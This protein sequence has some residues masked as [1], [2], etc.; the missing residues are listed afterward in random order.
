MITETYILDII[1]NFLEDN[2]F[3]KNKYSTDTWSRWNKHYLSVST[4]MNLKN[5]TIYV[6]MHNS[7]SG[8]T[9]FFSIP[10]TS[11][12]IAD[13]EKL[14]TNIATAILLS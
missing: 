11:A 10:L 13:V 2:G 14:K 4:I 5:L 3:L 8:Q 1:Q 9:K 7:F 6:R 12:E